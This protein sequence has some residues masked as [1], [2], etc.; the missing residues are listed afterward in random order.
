MNEMDYVYI[1][2]IFSLALVVIVLLWKIIETIRINSFVHK[3]E[4]IDFFD[5]QSKL[6]YSLFETYQIENYLDVSANLVKNFSTSKTFDYLVKYFGLQI[7][8]GK[9]IQYID[10]LRSLTEKAEEIENSSFIY[11]GLLSDY[12]PQFTMK[13][14]SPKGRSTSSYIVA[15]DS[16]GIEW[17]K[18][19]VDQVLSEQRRKKIQKQKMMPE[20]REAILRRDNWTCQRC[21]N[22]RL[23]EPN[24]AL[25]V[26]HIIPVS[27]GGKT[28][29]A[30]LQTLCWKCRR[31][32][33]ESVVL[34]HIPK[35][36]D[37]Q[38]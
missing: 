23:K 11:H 1:V 28:E 22:S 6:I 20:L 30:N 25:E 38:R 15:L 32:K 13:Y 33:N 26:V 36:S 3:L 4:E 9:T 17:L 7:D 27:K 35:K 16:E 10:D 34:K 5:K 31:G 2:V 37:Y 12:L 29:P 24:L 8:E 18:L 21:G 14:T 19:C